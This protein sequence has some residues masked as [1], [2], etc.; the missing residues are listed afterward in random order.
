MTN[1]TELTKKMI[2]R[3]ELND[4]YGHASQADHPE[5]YERMED[6]DIEIFQELA[7]VDG[8]EVIQRHLLDSLDSIASDFMNNNYNEESIDNISFYTQE[9]FIETFIVEGMDESSKKVFD[10]LFYWMDSDSRS[11]WI[12]KNHLVEMPNAYSNRWVDY[13]LI[14]NE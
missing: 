11:R 13:V 14:V 2:E 4:R 12:E 10:S 8:S 9:D 7:E 3:K 5:Q 1:F 6:L